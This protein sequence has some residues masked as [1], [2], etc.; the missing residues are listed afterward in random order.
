METLQNFIISGST[1]Y[2]IINAFLNI[3]YFNFIIFKIKRTAKNNLL[4]PFHIKSWLSYIQLALD[5]CLIETS[6]FHILNE[7]L[8][9]YLLIIIY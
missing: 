1:R 5:F 3:L 7:H 2:R 6:V 4:T 8:L 9:F